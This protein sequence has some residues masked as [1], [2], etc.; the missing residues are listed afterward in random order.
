M[1]YSFK[2]NSLYYVSYL[3]KHNLIVNILKLNTYVSAKAGINAAPTKYGE[4]TY[5]KLEDN[6]VLEFEVILYK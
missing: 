3:I 2:S 1:N 6:I 4:T 5:T